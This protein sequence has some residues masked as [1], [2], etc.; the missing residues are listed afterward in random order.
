MAT[1]PWKPASLLKVPDRAGH[2]RKWVRD[3]LISRLSSEG[4]TKVSKKTS[5]IKL[6]GTVLDGESQDDTVRMRELVLMEIT[7]ERAK[8]REKYFKSLS[9]SALQ[10][11]V[12]EFQRVASDGSG[13]ATGKIHVEVSKT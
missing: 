2:R 12:D 1:E 4:W 10:G 6:E 3:E 13:S 11:S 9:D 7:E 8:G 5:G